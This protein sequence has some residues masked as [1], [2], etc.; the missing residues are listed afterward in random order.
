MCND[1]GVDERD[2]LPGVI[3]RL[4]IHPVHRI[5]QVAPYDVEASGAGGRCLDVYGELDVLLLE[6]LVLR[7]PDQE[8]ELEEVRKGGNEGRPRPTKDR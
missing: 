2:C 1:Y 6:E 3:E 5:A 4:V 8:P 7:G